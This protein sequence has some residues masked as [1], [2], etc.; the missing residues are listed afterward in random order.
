MRERHVWPKREPRGSRCRFQVPPSVRPACRTVLAGSALAGGLILLA[1]CSDLHLP[2]LGAEG[3]SPAGGWV[4]TPT[5]RWLTEPGVT[6][7]TLLFCALETCADQVLVARFRLT[8]R[9]QDIARR[10]AENPEP[11]FASLPES[12]R[13]ASRPTNRQGRQPSSL[14][15]RISRFGFAGWSGARIMLESSTIPGRAAH[16]VVLARPRDHRLLVVV[17]PDAQRAEEAARAAAR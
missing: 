4:V 16:L 5:E 1:G 13:S 8:G 10:I 3:L 15:P 2:L 6:P 17:A 7:E 9:E 11:V 14:P 12:R